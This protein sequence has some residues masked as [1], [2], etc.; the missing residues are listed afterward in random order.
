[1]NPNNNF[2]NNQSN[3]YQ[4]QPNQYNNQQYDYN[5]NY[6][7]NQFSQQPQGTKKQNPMIHALISFFQNYVN[8][9]GRST[10]S[11]FWFWFLW[12]FI[13]SIILSFIGLKFLSMIYALATIIPE[14]A[15]G[16]RRLRDAGQSPW[17]FLIGF[18]P[19][20]GWI[21]LIVLDCMPSKP[22]SNNN[23]YGSNNNNF[24]GNGYQNNPN[25]YQGN[26]M[27]Q[28]NNNNNTF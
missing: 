16:I 3:G 6:N 4:T 5:Q 10:R 18:V 15:I 9:S 12:N 28:N 7:Q 13:F 21:I 17:W 14:I 25:M 23:G 2:Y 19:L 26:N 8:F 20:V 22:S 11:E 24:Y 27:Y 1:M